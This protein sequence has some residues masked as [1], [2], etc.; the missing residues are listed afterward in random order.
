MRRV[1]LQGWERRL[2]ARSG[3]FVVELRGEAVETLP[4]DAVEAIHLVGGAEITPAALGLALRAGI[5]LL[6]LTAHG[7]VIGRTARFGSQGAA[8]RLAQLRTILDPPRRLSIAAAVVTGKIQ[9]Q[10]AHLA[11]HQA[12]RRSEALSVALGRLRAAAARAPDAPD[13][14]TLRGIEGAAA[15]AYFAALGEALQSPHFTFTGRN[16]RPPR[17]PV[18]ATLS[19][20]YA[21]L[22]TEV[23]Q[24]TT[25]AGLDPGCGF[26]HDAGRDAPALAL[27][28]CEE[29]RPV[30]DALVLGLFNRR[31]LTPVD[32]IQPHLSAAD[33]TR[34]PTDADDPDPSNPPPDDDD[35]PPHAPDDDPRPPVHLAPVGRQVLLRA[36]A[37][38]L[39]DPT[40][41]PAA[42]GARYPLRDVLQHQSNLLARVVEGR[43]PAYTPFPWR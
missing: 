28:L 12:R 21:L 23:V 7:R 24:A 26:L 13:L 40:A 16:R 35:I 29:W 37:R 10:Y 14:D 25:R 38:R 18:N 41:S 43:A 42:D 19:F 39:A 36:W 8:R 27:D 1:V 32:F 15:R 5:D 3:A 6:H 4:T 20:A 22:V 9:N 33:T 17:D 34:P 2:T 30:V 31:E 11:R